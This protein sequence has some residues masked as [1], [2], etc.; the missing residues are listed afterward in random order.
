MLNANDLTQLV[1][2]IFVDIRS[3]SVNISQWFFFGWFYG[4]ICRLESLL[5]QYVNKLGCKMCV[6]ELDLPILESDNDL[7]FNQQNTIVVKVNS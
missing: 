3:L 6:N 4:T 2:N 7:H 5:N 1:K